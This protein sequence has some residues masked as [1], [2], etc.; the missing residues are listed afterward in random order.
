M[1][2]SH[3]TYALLASPET[4]EEGLSHGLGELYA[5]VF[6]EPPENQK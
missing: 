5:A 3:V 6:G 1:E 2:A 4:L